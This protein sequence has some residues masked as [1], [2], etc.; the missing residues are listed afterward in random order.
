MKEN[1]TEKELE[2]HKH[3]IHLMPPAYAE[4]AKE[5]KDIGPTAPIGT[6]GP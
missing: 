5:P 6:A 4:V 1:I 2:I 3:T